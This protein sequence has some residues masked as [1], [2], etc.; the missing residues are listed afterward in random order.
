MMPLVGRRRGG[1]GDVEARRALQ[2]LAQH[3]GFAGLRDEIDGAEGAGVPGVGLVVLAGQHDD[4][5]VGRGS[6]QLADQAEAFVGAV[7]NGREAEI[8]EREAGHVLELRDQAAGLGAGAG[9]EH[10]EVA[11]EHEVE[12]VGDERVI[13]DDQQFRLLAGGFHGAALLGN[14]CRI[15]TDG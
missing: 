15:V 4:L 7:R 8:D 11:A 13:V 10:L 3:V 14:R 6:E 1:L 2:Q 12:R 5:D 9:S